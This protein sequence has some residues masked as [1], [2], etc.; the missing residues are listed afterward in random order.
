MGILEARS[1]SIRHMSLRINMSQV[2][3]LKVRLLLQILLEQIVSRPLLQLTVGFRK[4]FVMTGPVCYC[5][6]ASGREPTGG[7][8][9]IDDCRS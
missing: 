8:A 1:L 3:V 9:N 4:K 7:S 2:R 5:E 6:P